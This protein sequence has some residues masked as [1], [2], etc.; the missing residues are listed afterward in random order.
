MR[1]IRYAVAM[2]VDGY[3]AGPSGEADWI[4]VDSEV[5]FAALWAQFDTLLM[6][7][8]TYEAASKRLGEAAFAGITTIVFSRT[9]KQQDHPEVTIVSELNL[10]CVQALRTRSG[11]DIWIMGGGG[12]FRSFL[13]SG[14]VDTVEVAVIPVLLG[15]GV[16]L[17]P[18]PYDPAKLRLLSHKVYRSGRVSLAYEVQH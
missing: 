3:I 17:L 10:D 14:H 8:R 11:K 2:S 7:R 1:K 15:G 13:D 18:P 4:G 6:G 16:P 12:L 5:D 9:M